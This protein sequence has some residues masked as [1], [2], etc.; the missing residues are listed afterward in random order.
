MENFLSEIWE[1]LRETSVCSI[2]MADVISVSHK[3]L[4]IQETAYFNKLPAPKEH[5]LRGDFT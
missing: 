3:P 5:R 2:T 4:L 1:V